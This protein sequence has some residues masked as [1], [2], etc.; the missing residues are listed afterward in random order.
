MSFH[1]PQDHD[2]HHHWLSWLLQHWSF[3]RQISVSQWDL[4]NEDFQQ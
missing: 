1:I 2:L 3:Y 4:E